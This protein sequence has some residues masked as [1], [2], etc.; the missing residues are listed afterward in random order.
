MRV[1]ECVFASLSLCVSCINH[2]RDGLNV[3]FCVCFLQMSEIR[4]QFA[5][6]THSSRKKL[7][8]EVFLLLSITT[9]TTFVYCLLFYTVIYF[10]TNSSNVKNNGFSMGNK[11]WFVTNSRNFAVVDVCVVCSVYTHCSQKEVG[12]FWFCTHRKCYKLQCNSHRIEWKSKLYILIF[13][14]SKIKHTSTAI[15]QAKIKKQKL[16][17]REFIKP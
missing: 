6:Y 8:I 11:S 1:C 17:K 14:I 9:T 12:N 13:G 4:T 7:C 10:S 3:F 5:T 15:L 2:I 16:L